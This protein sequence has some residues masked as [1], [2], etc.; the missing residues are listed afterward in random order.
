MDESFLLSCFSF[1]VA[2]LVFFDMDRYYPIFII[3]H[4]ANNQSTTVYLSITMKSFVYAFLLCI[5]FAETSASA[6]TTTQHGRSRR[7]RTAASATTAIAPSSYAPSTFVATAAAAPTA[8]SNKAHLRSR[9]TRI[10]DALEASTFGP[11]DCFH[12]HSH[13]TSDLTAFKATNP[14]V[15]INIETRVRNTIGVNANTTVVVQEETPLPEASSSSTSS[16]IRVLNTSTM[17][18]PSPQQESTPNV[19]TI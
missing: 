5:L 8:N 1:S 14:T 16:P 17:M 6:T 19:Q 3:N 9:R 18:T 4:Q 10:S 12:F 13:N 15:N 7:A 2:F 11:S